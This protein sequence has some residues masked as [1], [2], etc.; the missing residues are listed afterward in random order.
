MELTKENVLEILKKI[1][2][3]EV[4]GDIVTNNMVENLKVEGRQVLFTLKLPK[5]NDPFFNSI[6]KLVDRQLRKHFG[7]DVEVLVTAPVRVGP[8]KATPEYLPEVKNVVAVAS[9][10][11][12]VGKS[13]VAVNLAAALA[14]AGWKVG[15]LDADIY[16]PSAPKMLQL[17]GA[18]PS[19][20]KK[21]G[22]DMIVPLEKY[23]MKVLSI[24]FFVS[25]DD[26]LVWRGAMATSAIKQLLQQGDWGALDYLIVDL[27]PG[28]SDIHLTLVQEISVTGAIIVSTP[29]DVALADAI[30]GIAMFRS[31]KINV[32][33]LGLVENMA[34]FTPP[35]LP[36]KK[37]YIFG[38]GGAQKLSEKYN[39]PVLARIPIVQK[40]RESGDTG[41]P[42]ALE[43]DSVL[44]GI[45]E[46]LAEKV[47]EQVDKRNRE[48]PPTQ[49][50]IIT[51]H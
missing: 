16:G 15:L 41:I 20:V 28:T 6:K 5:P 31:D 26:A 2:H 32:P 7:D 34:W 29:Q 37:Y 38:E 13:M 44:A 40:I 39:V 51:K 47:V 48:L 43:E 49:R 9:G 4:A 21:N 33:V 42:V 24:G 45:F 17:E 12:G 10:K 50:V 30:K 3:P 1:K 36:D 22:V 19:V 46:E 18:M 14:K 8:L 35:E 23:G 25:E 27:P 11:G